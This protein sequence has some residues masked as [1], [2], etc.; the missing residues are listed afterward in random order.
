MSNLKSATNESTPRFNGKRDQYWSFWNQY[1]AKLYEGG[2]NYVLVDAYRLAMIGHHPVYPPMPIMNPVEDG[3]DPQAV[4]EY[5][6]NKEIFRAELR[7]YQNSVQQYQKDC[8]KAL[9]ILLS[10]LS[11]HLT[12]E[13]QGKING[14]TLTSNEEELNFAV[15]YIRTQYGPNDTIDAGRIDGEI[16]DLND[17]QGVRHMH[18]TFQ[19]L[20]DELSRIR[21]TDANGNVELDNDGN[22]R[23]YK[24]DVKKCRSFYL[25]RLGANGNEAWY[26]LK[27]KYSSDPNLTYEAMMR[28]I[29]N[30]LKDTE[31]WDYIGP[32]KKSTST[33]RVQN[34]TV[35]QPSGKRKQCLNCGRLN[36]TTPECL[37]PTCFRCNKTFGSVE[38][39]RQHDLNVHADDDATKKRA[40]AHNELGS[41]STPQ[42]KNKRQNTTTTSSSMPPDNVQE[43]NDSIPKRVTKRYGKA[44]GGTST[45]QSK[46]TKKKTSVN[47][48]TT[49]ENQDDADA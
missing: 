42:Q 31:E 9:G 36:H 4:A 8:A 32:R 17:K 10:Q 18:R 7:S 29:E 20:Q 41:S 39:R 16:R 30:M 14:E 27:L 47:F 43:N 13:L 34:A 2:I 23:T 35:S 22:P 37:S 33:T 44:S 11:P 28:E 48:E 45:Q 40:H 38:A 26:N 49:C 3:Y 6:E 19:R 46:Q 24:Y 12:A 5:E 15:N 21:I 1:M 25:D